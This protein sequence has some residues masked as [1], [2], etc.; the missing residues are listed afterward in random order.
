MVVQ[1]NTERIQEL[2]RKVGDSSEISE[3]F[4]I[5]IREL[6]LPVGRSELDLVREALSQIG[7]PG[8]D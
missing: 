1:N 3:K 7:A 8:I 4:G 6:P 2:E 5:A